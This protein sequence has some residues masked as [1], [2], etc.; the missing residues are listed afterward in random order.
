[1]SP[2]SSSSVALAV[3]DGGSMRRN[4]AGVVMVVELSFSEGIGF[5][6]NEQAVANANANTNQEPDFTMTSQVLAVAGSTLA[7]RV[8]ENS[9]AEFGWYYP[10][11]LPRK[12]SQ[13]SLFSSYHH[14]WPG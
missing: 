6:A 5:C 10:P 13:K 4:C 9:A 14:R 1:M 11:L 7:Q 2:F 3:E 8:A 12:S